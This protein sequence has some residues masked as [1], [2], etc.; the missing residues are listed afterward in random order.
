MS[1]LSA[2]LRSAAILGVAS[3]AAA[4][5]PTLPTVG[6]KRERVPTCGH[7]QVYAPPV[8]KGDSG[9]ILLIPKPCPGT[10]VVE[11]QPS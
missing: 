5:A 6:E 4:C 11:E 3:L 9:R 7:E 8:R 10:A 1:S 2:A